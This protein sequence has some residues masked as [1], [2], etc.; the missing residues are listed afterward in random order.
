[1]RPNIPP[2]SSKPPTMT[3]K[4][5]PNPFKKFFERIT[6]KEKKEVNDAH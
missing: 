6:K 2:K 5:G 4:G 3:E 1:M